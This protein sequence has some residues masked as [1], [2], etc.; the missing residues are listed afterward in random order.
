MAPDPPAAAPDAG[1]TRLCVKNVPKHVDERRLKVHFGQQGMVTD[2]KL[3]RTKRGESRKMAFVGFRTETEARAAL[4][5]FNQTFLDTSRLVVE[6]AMP[7]GANTLPRPWSKYSEGSS[8]F[9][10]NGSGS[11][12]SS[13]SKRRMADEA[14]IGEE[15]DEDNVTVVAAKVKKQ[16]RVSKDEFL[17]TM[18][19]RSQ[20][21]FWGND[22]LLVV[23]E[24][25]VK[26]SEQ[27]NQERQGQQRLKVMKGKNGERSSKRN[28]AGEEELSDDGHQS[29][30]DREEES[31]E[32]EDGEEEVDNEEY[33]PLTLPTPI[34]G[35]SDLDYLRSKV[36]KG[37]EQEMGGGT[38]TGS[39]SSS[40]ETTKK[41][42]E[43]DVEE[44]IYEDGSSK[45]GKHKEE[46]EEES[47]GPSGLEEHD[48]DKESHN[49]KPLSQPQELPNVE[50]TGRLF[51]RNL[52][53]STTEEDLMELLTHHGQVAEVHL[54]LDDT[55]RPKGF[56]FASFLL[57]EDAARALAAVDGQAF[58]G[59]LLHVLPAKEPPKDPLAELDPMQARTYKEKKEI[60]RRQKA[61]D[62]RGWNAS[63]LRSETV[64]EAVADR[65]QLEKGQVLD[66]DGGEMAVK[67]ALGETFLLAEN[68]EFFKN[69]GVDLT[70]LESAA[71]Q[72]A[73]RKQQ[74][75]AKGNGG[76][77]A[78]VSRSKTTLLV[79]NLPYSTTQE[80]LTQLFGRFGQL[81][82]VIL[83][84]SRTI[85]L[86]DFLEAADAKKA[87]KGLAYKRFQHVPLYLEWAPMHT[88][89]AGGSRNSDVEVGKEVTADVAAPVETTQPQKV[90]K[91]ALVEVVEK[92]V[93]EEEPDGSFTLFVKN[94]NFATTEE[95]LLAYF[96]SKT[97]GVRTVAIPKKSAPVSAAGKE[98]EKCSSSS[99]AV[100]SMGYGFVEYRS[101][102][103]AKAALREMEGAML[104]GHRLQCKLSDKR[105]TARP[106]TAAKNKQKRTKL[107]VRNVAFQATSKELKELFG[108]FGKVKT[109]RLPKKFDGSH[110]GFAFVEFLTAQEAGNAFVALSST[111]L[112]GKRLVLEWAED[113]EDIETLREKASKDAR[114]GAASAL[115]NEG[116]GGGAGEGKKKWESAFDEGF[117]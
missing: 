115:S 12:S 2:A 30:E 102:A 86:V 101:V 66:R 112:Y 45:N 36:K 69:E 88:F 5:Y 53:F 67:L 92:K 20:T 58:Q 81:G 32:E 33:A 28:P 43:E 65:L 68:R 100:L 25:H 80:E 62:E 83:P 7:R 50:E 90:K 111:H 57:P 19:P 13:S 16:R 59:R 56:A 60:E 114:K 98:K 110:R 39:R 55:K 46:E 44:K 104:D 42:E 106:L 17:A 14:E 26:M 8:R 52:P 64:V 93:E 84:P 27:K 79:K 108:S 91:I 105:L 21:K 74:Q 38:S 78:T 41:K 23:P 99:S 94:L 63:Y 9:G 85:A 54:P 107:V 97:Q 113:K 1:F 3:L 18:M 103:E 117:D 51:L 72:Q 48:D 24:A 70:V 89:K 96:K 31:E 40:G 15:D 29:E 95:K 22:E 76:A 10:N 71:A 87:F 49:T 6:A 47:A 61:G 37:L 4:E 116:G 35:I 77:V 11:S 75:A 109:V 34:A 73:R 82:R